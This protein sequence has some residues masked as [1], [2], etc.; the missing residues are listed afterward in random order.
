VTQNPPTQLS[1]LPQAGEHTAAGQA[2]D[3]ELAVALPPGVAQVIGAVLLTSIVGDLQAVVRTSPQIPPD[4][5]PGVDHMLRQQSSSLA[6]GAGGMFDRLPPTT[7]D[8]MNQARRVAT[9]QL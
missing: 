3:P 1:P 6:F 2:T 5:K 8:E 4:A 9:T 7:R